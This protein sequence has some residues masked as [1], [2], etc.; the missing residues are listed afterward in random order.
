V[1]A[2]SVHKHTHPKKMNSTELQ[3]HSDRLRAFVH[4]FHKRYAEFVFAGGLRDVK[5]F[6]PAFDNSAVFQR[7][8]GTRIE[9]VLQIEDGIAF[10]QTNAHAHEWWFNGHLLCDTVSQPWNPR[11]ADALVK[12]MQTVNMPPH[13]PPLLVNPR[14]FPFCKRDG[15]LPWTFVDGRLSREF[16]QDMQKPLSFYGGPKWKDVLMPLPEHWD[17][18]RECAPLRALPRDSSLPTGVFRG[19]LTGRFLDDRNIRIQLARLSKKHPVLLDAG[20]SKW[21]NRLRVVTFV[22]ESSTLVLEAPLPVE[23]ALMRA[24]MTREEQCRHAVLV[25]A[26]G[27]VGSSRLAW[28]LCSGSAVLLVEDDSCAAPDMWFMTPDFR[29]RVLVFSTGFAEKTH[30]GIVF[31]CTPSEVV[32]ALDVLKNSPDLV[33]RVSTA[34]LA[35]SEIMFSPVS[36][37]HHLQMACSASLA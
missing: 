14:D 5:F 6:D 30:Q 7:F 18:W 34:C 36:V 35:W 25:Y 8:F 23:V 10:P 15:S 26:P 22:A 29:S 3:L 2:N 19:T 27:H 21:S 17:V 12:M 33:A 4:T 28:Q 9:F 16:E 11:A 24:E 13:A 20:F 1:R 37:Q 31:S 32:L